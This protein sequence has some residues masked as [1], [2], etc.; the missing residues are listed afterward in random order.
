MGHAPPSSFEFGHATQLPPLGRSPSASPL[1]AA[2]QH[3]SLLDCRAHVGCHAPRSRS[4][5]VCVLTRTTL[6][7]LRGAPPGPRPHG[8]FVLFVSAWFVSAGLGAVARRRTK[9]RWPRSESG[10]VGREKPRRRMSL[11]LSPHSNYVAQ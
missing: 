3:Y 6:V 10:E 4:C 2:L 5:T 9:E 1:A 11:S 8:Q 7:S